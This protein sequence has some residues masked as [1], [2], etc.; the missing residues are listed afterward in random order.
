MQCWWAP[1]RA[2]QLSMAVTARVIWLCACVRYWPYPGVGTCASVQLFGIVTRMYLYVFACY[3]CDP[4]VLVCYPYVLVWCFSHD[5]SVYTN[6]HQMLQG[7]FFI[8]HAGC[9]EQRLS[10][11]PDLLENPKS[12]TICDRDRKNPDFHL[13]SDILKWIEFS[14][15]S[16]C[17]NT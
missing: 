13:S 3:R 2:K 12:I 11:H 17:K 6:C 5:L 14:Y 4:Y 7:K 9:D 10:N 15:D 8:F 1:T 16:L